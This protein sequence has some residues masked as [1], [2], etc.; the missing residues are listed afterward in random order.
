MIELF[1]A[2]DGFGLPDLEEAPR[3]KTIKPGDLV[4]IDKD[5]EFKG[6]SW[7]EG[8]HNISGVV[9]SIKGNEAEIDISKDPSRPDV[10]KYKKTQ[11]RKEFDCSKCGLPTKTTDLGIRRSEPPR[12]YSRDWEVKTYCNKCAD[13]M[14]PFYYMYADYGGTYGHNETPDKEEFT[15]WLENILHKDGANGLQDWE[16]Y[17]VPGKYKHDSDNQK[18]RAGR[19]INV[20]VEHGSKVKIKESA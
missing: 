2:V 5:P 4:L 12:G 8:I 20:D 18:R 19:R 17:L 11:L 7:E 10:R 6:H 13:V 3:G 9:K 14:P 16:L 15:R 1:E